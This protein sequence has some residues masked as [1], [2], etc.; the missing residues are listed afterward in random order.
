MWI[1]NFNSFLSRKKSHQTRL[2]L[3]F[4]LQAPGS[5]FAPSFITPRAAW[6][7][8][9]HLSVLTLDPSFPVISNPASDSLGAQIQFLFHT[10][11]MYL[12]SPR[13]FT[14]LVGF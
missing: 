7:P 6:I 14:G 2:S 4:C 5:L 10:W 12:I 3:F 11:N 9:I 1:D 13:S 8:E